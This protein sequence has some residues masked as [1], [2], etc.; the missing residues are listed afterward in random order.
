MTAAAR[1]A[2][3]VTGSIISAL[4]ITSLQSHILQEEALH[5]GATGDFTCG[6]AVAPFA[7]SQAPLQNSV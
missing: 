5:H 7:N 2:V 6:M 4:N 1:F 3:R